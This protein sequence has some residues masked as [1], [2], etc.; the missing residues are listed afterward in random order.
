VSSWGGLYAGLGAGFRSTRTD[1]TVTA[2]PYNCVAGGGCVLGQPLNDTA[3]RVS[4]YLGWNWQFAPQWLAGIEGDF[5]FSDKTTSLAGM[6]Y[7]ITRAGFNGTADEHFSVRTGWDASARGRLGFLATPST[8]LYATGGGTWLRVESQSACSTNAFV[9]ACR[10]G[11]LTPS[12][13][14]NASTK[15]GWTMGGG[16]ETRLWQNWL[17]RT[18]YRYA[19]YGHIS[20]TNT[21]SLNF[22]PNVE[23]VSYDTRVRTHTLTF[24]LA[25]QFD[26]TKPVMAKF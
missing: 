16:F 26:P 12:V 20:N 2:N 5:G 4:P 13:I 1:V 10:S 15:L 11:V 6:Y 17:V 3:A 21:R 18:E 14:T 22:L 23:L 8:L 7:P 19:D 9:G 24:G 25:Y